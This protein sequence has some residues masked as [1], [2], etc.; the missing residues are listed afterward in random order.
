MY[1]TDQARYGPKL[2]EAK[3]IHLAA[4]D[5]RTYELNL[6]LLFGSKYARRR[7]TSY[8]IEPAEASE[9]PLSLPAWI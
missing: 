4:L 3:V 2:L 8:F 1:F 9:C 7:R 5:F 6:A